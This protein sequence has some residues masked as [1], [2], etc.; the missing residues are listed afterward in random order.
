MTGSQETRNSWHDGEVAGG[1]G[2]GLPLG[3][4]G[5]VLQ[6]GVWT[7]ELSWNGDQCQVLL[8][9]DDALPVDGAS[10]Y[11]RVHPMSCNLA[12]EAAVR[13]SHP[14]GS[15]SQASLPP[16]LRA[17][18]HTVEL[19]LHT[20]SA[21]SGRADMEAATTA[22]VPAHPW[23]RSQAGVSEAVSISGPVINVGS[24]P[25][26]ETA[27]FTLGGAVIASSLSVPVPANPAYQ[28]LLIQPDM[29]E[30]LGS[31][32]HRPRRL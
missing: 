3:A 9:V 2:N 18:Q 20:Q 19:P 27:Y 16:K 14:S 6:R 32:L 28:Y 5:R 30:Y 29:A 1:A 8:E 31:W 12:T 4:S 15:E 13:I 21:L 22:K 26:T 25:F 24:W 7:T 17:R 11:I 23:R 10:P